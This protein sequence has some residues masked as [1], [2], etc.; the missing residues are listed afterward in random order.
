MLQRLR[1]K[2]F[3]THKSLDLKLGQITTIVGETD[4]GKSAILRGLKWLCLNEPKGNGFIQHGQEEAVAKVLVDGKTVSRIRGKSNE[5]RIGKQV[6]KS[7]NN[8]VPTPVADLLAVQA[9]NFQGQM[10][11]PFWFDLSPGQVAQ[12]LNRI[13][14]LDEIDRILSKAAS[15]VRNSKAEMVVSQQRHEKASQAYQEFEWLPQAKAKWKSISACFERLENTRSDIDSLRRLVGRI[16]QHKRELRRLRELTTEGQILIGQAKQARKQ[17]KRV[18][19]LRLLTNEL[20]ISKQLTEMDLPV[21]SKLTESY[22]QAER[23]AEG[24]ERLAAIVGKVQ[25]T[26]D[27]LCQTEKQL[28][29]LKGKLKKT[30]PVCPTCQRP[31]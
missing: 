5:Y 22:K 9:F 12:E 6:Y 26:K 10:D 28:Q 7:F 2:N 29:Q 24:T 25:M 15:R 8:K 17:S 21:T 3:Q 23:T 19:S 4:S 30:V 13:V 16:R 18:D 1:L 27:K 31:M 20:R 14:N 11:A